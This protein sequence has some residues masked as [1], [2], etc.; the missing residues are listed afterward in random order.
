LTHGI[1]AHDVGSLLR[2]RARSSRRAVPLER[3]EACEAA[4][5]DRGD[6]LGLLL[7]CLPLAFVRYALLTNPAQR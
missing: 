5:S 2:A 6:K 7:L 4:F 1:P 3:S